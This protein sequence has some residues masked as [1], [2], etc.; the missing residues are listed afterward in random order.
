MEKLTDFLKKEKYHLCGAKKGG[1]FLHLPPDHEKK[2]KTRRPVTCPQQK[3][4]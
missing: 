1:I 3:D 4:S 2:K